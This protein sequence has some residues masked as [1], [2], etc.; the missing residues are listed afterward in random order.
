MTTTQDA[1][2]DEAGQPTA[3]ARR[4]DPETSHAAARS[5]RAE[6]LRKSQEAVLAVFHAQGAMT[7]VEL[8]NYYR[9]RAD[10]ARLPQQSES[11]IR[12]RRSELVAA[13]RVEDSG[14]RV[15][16]PSGRNAIVWKAVA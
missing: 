1:L 7:D 8:V 12:T 15:K 3:H 14:Q 10:F 13:G 9:K 2:F 5:I 4:T 11:G 6:Q 16:L